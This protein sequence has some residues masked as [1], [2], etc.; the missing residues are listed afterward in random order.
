MSLDFRLALTLNYKLVINDQELT[1]TF[2]SQ[3]LNQTNDKKG[4]NIQ[5]QFPRWFLWFQSCPEEFTNFQIHEFQV[6]VVR[7]RY[8]TP[9]G[10][11]T[12]KHSFFCHL[13]IGIENWYFLNA[14]FDELYSKFYIFNYSFS[15]F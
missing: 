7:I 13:Q 10:W 11:S 6:Q 9:Q 5:F 3:T 1:A 2:S 4:K 12:Q 8:K 14:E 15:I